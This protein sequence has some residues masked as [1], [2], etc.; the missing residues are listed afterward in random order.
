DQRRRYEFDGRYRSLRVDGQHAM[1]HTARLVSAFFRPGRSWISKYRTSPA[2]RFLW[3]NFI[4]SNTVQ[5]FQ[6]ASTT[7]SGGGIRT[8]NEPNSSGLQW[9]CAT[10][11][12]V[13]SGET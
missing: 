11:G 2:H 9:R 5:A 13:S 10:Q 3:P 7:S 6:L 12:D 1:G 4:S 8:H